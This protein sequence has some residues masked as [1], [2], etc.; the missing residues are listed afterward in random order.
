M[1]RASIASCVLGLLAYAPSAA[2]VEHQLQLTAR[3]GFAWASGTHGGPAPAVE[4]HANW[5]LNDAFS[6][7]ANASWSM[8]FPDLARNGPRHDAGLSVGVF[9][10]FDYLRVVPYLGVGARADVFVA[11]GLRWWSP[12]A[13]ARVGVSWLLKRSLALDLQAAYAFAFLDGDRAND[14]V[15]VTAGVSWRLDL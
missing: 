10:A 11:P 1:K 15:S 3:A 5:G 7:Y 6:L 12:A 8:A 2:A 13:E 14:L 4:V 9:Y